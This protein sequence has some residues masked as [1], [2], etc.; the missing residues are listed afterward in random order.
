[1]GYDL[2]DLFCYDTFKIV[3]V[4]DRRLG[5]PYYLFMICTAAYII[6]SIATDQL[7]LRKEDVT[8]GSVRI[9]IQPPAAGVTTPAYCGRSPAGSCLFFD[10][11]QV[12]PASTD[13]N[14]G[15]GMFI[16]TRITLT[17][18]TVPANGCDIQAPSSAGCM[19]SAPKENGITYFVAD[20][21]NFTARINPPKHTVR[22][23]S[24]AIASRSEDM[25]GVVKD[26]A[27]KSKR[28]YV[29]TLMSDTNLNIVIRDELGGDTSRLHIRGAPAPG[30]VMTVKDLLAVANVTSLDMLSESP[31]ARSDETI[32]E[33]GFVLL[34]TIEYGNRVENSSALGYTYSA[35]YI[36]GT[37]AKVAETVYVGPSGGPTGVQV[38]NR[39]GIRLAVVQKG[40]LGSFD[41]MALLT[42]IV[43]SVALLRV[44]VL[45]VEFMLVWVM[46]EKSVYRQYKIETTAD[47]S[48]LRDEER[49]KSLPRP[50]MA[51][52]RWQVLTGAK[53]AVLPAVHRQQHQPRTH[54]V[55]SS[56]MTVKQSIAFHGDDADNE[57]RDKRA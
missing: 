42:S 51:D 46:P 23:K 56:E 45:V 35:T 11:T 32:R 9:T 28:V 21:E 1:M 22:G 33:S 24:N 38:R 37:E 12:V 31:T 48:D 3:R 41:F 18:A 49:A 34:L 40:Q 25:V 10:A 57:P 17:N 5:I 29:P 4:R 20:I 36:K 43:A 54:P 16:T 39:H 55:L 26:T 8:N 15:G 14:G 47:F 6:Y 30:D 7:Y 19:V 2:D 13:E 53:P 44:S 52:H 50:A 27:G